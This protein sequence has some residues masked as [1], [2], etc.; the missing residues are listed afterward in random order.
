[1][2]EMILL[3]YVVGKNENIAPYM[4]C[5]DMVCIFDCYCLK[6]SCRKFKGVLFIGKELDRRVVKIE[7]CVCSVNSIR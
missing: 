6:L 7:I 3:Q 5:V 2:D 1:M 4:V